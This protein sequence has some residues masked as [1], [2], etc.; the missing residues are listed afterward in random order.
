MVIAEGQK[1]EGVGSAPEH[2]LRSTYLWVNRLLWPIVSAI[3]GLTTYW[4]FALPHADIVV[5]GGGCVFG[6][7]TGVGILNSVLWWSGD[8]QTS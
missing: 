3:S 7:F 6:V 8:G 2:A 4:T 1:T 5:L